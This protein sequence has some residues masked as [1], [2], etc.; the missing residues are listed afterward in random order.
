MKTILKAR[1]ELLLSRK[2][3]DI[4]KEWKGEKKYF[5]DNSEM[6]IVGSQVAKWG[7]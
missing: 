5:I 2:S 3:S 1:H 7:V 4:E 6:S